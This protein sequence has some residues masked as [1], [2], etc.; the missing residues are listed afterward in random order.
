MTGA[1]V[2]GNRHRVLGVQRWENN[3]HT[4]ELDNPMYKM[5]L[6]VYSASPLLKHQIKN[7]K[8]QVLVSLLYH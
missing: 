5:Y 3:V 2:K 1:M 4:V 6:L 7:Y 8:S